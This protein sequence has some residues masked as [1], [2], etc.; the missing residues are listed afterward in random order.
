MPALFALG[1]HQALEAIQGSLQPSE[2]LMAFLDDVYVTTLPDR[3]ATVEQSVEIQLWDHARIHVNQGKTQVWNRCGVRPPDCEHL[4]HKAD[5]T[6]NDVWRGDPGLPSHKQGVTILGTPLG[7]AEIV[8]GRLA[9]KIE[10]HGI[11]FDRITKVTDFQR[12]WLLLLFCA[13]STANYVLREVHPENSFQFAIHHDAGIRQCLEN[14]LHI[15]VTDAVWAMASLPFGSGGLSLRNAERLRTT[16]HWSSWAD[17]LTMFRERHPRVAVHIL[18]SL[19]QGRGGFHLEAAHESR[20]RLLRAGV[21]APEWGAVDRGQRPGSHPDEEFLRFSRTGWQ[22][23]ASTEI[24]EVFFG[25]TVWPRLNPTDRALVRSQRGPMASIRFFTP[26]VS[27]ASRFDPQSFRVLLRRLWCQLP[28]CSATCRCGQP[29]DSRGHHRGACATAGGFG[30]P[31]VSAGELCG[32]DLQG[33][34]QHPCLRLGPF[35]RAKSRQPSGSADG[36]PLFHG[37]QLAVDTTMVSTVRADGVCRRQCTERD[38]AA[39]DQAR[40]TEE[41]TYPELTGQQGRARLVVLACETG[42]R[43]SEEGQSFLRHLARARARSEPREM[44]LAAR[45]AWLRRWC[46]GRSGVCVVPVGAQR[47]L[48]S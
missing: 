6:P 7:R 8:E 15:S 28:L 4:F 31:R 13:A 36:L 34:R 1:Q 33:V 14:L 11:L 42:G 41:R 26:P 23:F 48:G 45:R 18:V 2:I 30:S 16:A 44:R 10:E 35:S 12:T 9:E 17:T 39:L 40:R 27:T 47:R 21:A 3:V 25:T 24:E 5:G 32:T 19:S 22:S 37:A 20:D 38:G 46:T 43:W 29:L